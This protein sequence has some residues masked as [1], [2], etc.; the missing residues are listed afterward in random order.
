MLKQDLAHPDKRKAGPPVFIVGCPRSGTSLLAALLDRHSDLAVPPETFLFRD[1]HPELLSRGRLGGD[2]LVD[3]LQK[4]WPICALNL[5]RDALLE[6]IGSEPPAH[7]DLFRAILDTYAAKQAKPRWVE[8]TPVHLFYVPLILAWYPDARVLCVVRDGRDVARSLAS[9]PWTHGDLGFHSLF[10]TRCARLTTQF[11]VEYPENFLNVRFEELVSH[12]EE[13]LREVG[14]FI[15]APFQRDQ[16]VAGRPSDSILEQ[17]LEWKAKALAGP[18]SKRV[19]AWKREASRRERLVMGIVMGSELQRC[20]YDPDATAVPGP[21]ERAILIGRLLIYQ[22]LF[23]IRMGVYHPAV[24]QRIRWLRRLI[25]VKGSGRL[26]G[27]SG[28]PME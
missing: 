24:H 14:A 20:G 16:L 19:Q 6:R 21:M 22:A 13:S 11:G 8:K 7:R 9:V 27:A 23:S 15:Q 5:D 1:L 17:E 10:W 12:P 4:H 25:P 26:S 28:P 3:F 2:A 18:D